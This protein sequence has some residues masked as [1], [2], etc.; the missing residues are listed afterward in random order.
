MKISIALL[1]EKL[2][3]NFNLLRKFIK[4]VEGG[5]YSSGWTGNLFKP[6]LMEI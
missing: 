1:S 6:R 3:L 2:L 4:H 5:I